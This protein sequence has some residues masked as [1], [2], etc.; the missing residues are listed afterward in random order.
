MQPAS[1]AALV[2][3]PVHQRVV[4]YGN[5]Q[6]WT[7]DDTGWKQ[8]TT[9][10]APAAYTGVA[11]AFD[12]DL[13]RTV[14]FGGRPSSGQALD[15]TWVLE[16]DTWR[17]LVLVMH[18]EARYDA[19]LTYDPVR[20][21]ALLTGGTLAV[22]AL[23]DAW[24]LVGDQWFEIPAPP[25]ARASASFTFDTTRR[26]AL[27]GGDYEAGGGGGESFVELD[28][29]HWQYQFPTPSTQLLGD[30]AYDPY[31]HALLTPGV[32]DTD[33]L[34]A[35]GVVRWASDETPESCSGVDDLDGDSLLG[36]ADPDCYAYCDPTCAP[37][38]SCP[39]SRPRCGDGMCA[40]PLET[41][42]RCPGDCP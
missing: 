24:Q 4:A 11:L 41:S 34:C 19:S 9:P 23:T 32:E 35:M 42:A 38:A 40:A 22:N 39:S 25:A 20:K 18:P 6:T 33:D 14:L 21:R 29:Q 5:R 16:G 8:L 36:C 3:D 12:T 17:Q 15:E 30:L 37:G 28:D 26:R 31:R 13:G 2:Y 7:F 1:N 10:T 27:L